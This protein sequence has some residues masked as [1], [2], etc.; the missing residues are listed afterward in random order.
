MPKIARGS[1][2]A[3]ANM[4]REN[5]TIHNPGSIQISDGK[6]SQKIQV[7]MPPAATLGTNCSTA[8]NVN[9]RWTTDDERCVRTI[10]SMPTAKRQSPAAAAQST[11]KDLGFPVASG[12]Q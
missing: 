4:P 11:T 3:E 8:S 9:C 12:I 5:M 2:R 6:E 10:I 1:K 7:N